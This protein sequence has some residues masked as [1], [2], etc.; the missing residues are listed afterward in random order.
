MIL[1]LTVGVLS[2]FLTFGGGLKLSCVLIIAL[3]VENC[4]TLTYDNITNECSVTMMVR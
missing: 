3:L 1:H 2:F 4:N